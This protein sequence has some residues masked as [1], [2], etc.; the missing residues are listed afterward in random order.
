MRRT[1]RS[2]RRSLPQE[3]LVSN[4]DE[5]TRLNQIL[6]WMII[7]L[8]AVS[9]I[10]LGSTPPIMWTIWGGLT[11]FVTL[12][13]VLLLGRSGRQAS[14][15]LTSLGLGATVHLVFCLYLVVQI[16]PIG[17]WFGGFA[18][19]LSDGSIVRIGTL[20]IAPGDTLLMLVRM[21]TYA[22]L[23]YLTTQVAISDRRRQFLMRA[24][25]IVVT[26]HALYGLVAL[27]QLGDTVLG[28]PKW[29]YFGSATGTFLNRNN[30]ATYMIFGMACAAALAASGLF[31]LREGQVKFQI[32]AGAALY[33]VVVVILISTITTTNSRMGFALGWVA[34][35]VMAILILAK[36]A[37]S[38]R[39]AV[40]VLPLMLVAIAILFF[41]YGQSLWAR[42]ENSE[43][44]FQ[45]R[46]RL[47]GQIL[48]LIANRL[49]TGYGG[50]TFGQAFPIVH[51]QDLEPQLFWDKAHDTY[52]TLWSEMGV[53]FGSLP[54]LLAGLLAATLVINLSKGRGSWTAQAPALVTLAVAA[55][56]SLVDF[57][58]EIEAVAFLFV[59]STAIGLAGTK[60]EARD[61]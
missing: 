32:D 49:W 55:L 60:V 56:H 10:P 15:G 41:V 21:L 61:V 2:R 11:G 13:Y 31:R 19:T 4:G 43:F 59:V 3:S 39:A 9:P 24:I 40:I 23:F 42:F 48:R 58:L 33:L 34:L 16:L 54:M 36:T 5:R 51:T 52:L 20:S 17:T 47:Y 30:F 45:D 18:L 37:K 6:M 53:I 7:V 22:M 25:V 35:G 28:V 1:A 57:S 38:L 27:F 26:A 46:L 12:A 29:K 50:G 44:E 8:L 14:V